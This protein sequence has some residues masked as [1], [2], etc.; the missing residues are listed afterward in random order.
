MLSPKTRA[1]TRPGTAKRRNAKPNAVNRLGICYSKARLVDPW[2][3][4]KINGLS[5]RSAPNPCADQ[6]PASQTATPTV[7]PFNPGR[8]PRIGRS[9][10]A[11]PGGP[12]TGDPRPG[13]HP[14]DSAPVGLEP[15]IAAPSSP[16]GGAPP[17]CRKTWHSTP[18]PW[19]R[20][21]T[22]T[23]SSTSLASTTSSTSA[24]STSSSIP[25][26]AWRTCWAW[27][28]G[29]SAR[30]CA[31]P[32]GAMSAAPRRGPLHRAHAA[33][34]RPRPFNRLS[35]L[36]RSGTEFDL[37]GSTPHAGPYQTPTEKRPCQ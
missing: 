14:G 10:G 15:A 30:L 2:Q 37:G 9:G 20:R 12:E 19:S 7:H 17:G 6:H 8:R 18:G 33:P 22:P 36:A 31:R 13:R 26:E 23:R 32:I 3:S 35:L 4:S 11:A 27:C 24:R 5:R 28:S 34:S 29:G 1:P 21:S 16:T 25:A